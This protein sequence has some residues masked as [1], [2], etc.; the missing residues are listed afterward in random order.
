MTTMQPSS[1]NPAVFSLADA[2]KA[3]NEWHFNCGPGAICGVLNMTPE[4]IRPHLSDFESKGYTNP[5]LMFEILRNLAVSWQL[6]YRGD[7]PD[8][9]F[10]YPDLG[11]IRIQWAGPWTKPGVPMQARYRHTHWAGMRQT[12]DGYEAFDINA[13]CVGGWLP[14]A[15]WR[16]DLIP[17]LIRECEPKANG[18]WWP[19]HVLKILFKEAPSL[20]RK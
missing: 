3:D 15:E 20:C 18:Q 7:E 2:E 10:A 17:W 8:A 4:E 1:S 5:T 11:L 6:I 16:T 9:N 12:T 13:M 19:T 14:L